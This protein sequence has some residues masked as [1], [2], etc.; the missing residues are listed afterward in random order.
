MPPGALPTA[1]HLQK[2]SLTAQAHRREAFVGWLDFPLYFAFTVIRLAALGYATYWFLSQ[3]HDWISTILAVL[4]VPLLLPVIF[5]QLSWFALAIA[6]RPEPRRAPVGFSVAAVTSFDPKSESF[7]MLARTLSALVAMDYKHETWVLDEG[8]EP[9]VRQLCREL[10]VN[11]FSRKGIAPFQAESG[12]FE[13]A[14]KH[15]N[16]NSWLVGHG[17]AHYDF[18]AN[19]DPDHVPAPVYLDAVLGHFDDPAIGYVQCAQAYYNQDA[20][21]VARGAAEETY[22]YYSSV[23]AAAYR[24]GHPVVTGC[25]TIHRVRALE[26]VDGFAAHPADDVLTTSNYREAGWRGVYIP[27]I[28][29]RGLVPVSWRSYI[30]QQRR[31]A[32]SLLDLKLHASHSLHPHSVM[33]AMQGIRYFL[34]GFFALSILLLIILALEGAGNA[35]SALGITL[36]L[37]CVFFLTNLYKQR[38]Y[39]DPPTECGIPWRAYLVRLVKWPYT[40]AAVIDVIGKRR[41]GYGTTPKIDVGQRERTVM[42]PQL[43]LALAIATVWIVSFWTGRVVNP[44]V[45][46]LGFIA[47]AILIAVSATDLIHFPAAHD[48]NRLAPQPRERILSRLDLLPGF[49]LAVLFL[50]WPLRTLNGTVALQ[51]SARHLMNGVFLYDLVR[52]GHIFEP[53]QFAFRYFA[54]FPALSMPY[55]PPL[56]PLFEAVLYAVFG[57]KFTVARLAVAI[58]VSVSAFLFYRLVLDQNGSRITA[59]VT[60]CSFLFLDLS[61]RLEQDVMLEFPALVFVLAAMLSL[62]RIERQEFSWLAGLSFG[63]WA[64]AGIWTKQ[65]VFLPIAPFLYFLCGGNRRAFLRPALWV[66]AAVCGIS[67]VLLALASARIGLFGM[68]GN[69]RPMSLTDTI[70]HNLNFY[71]HALPAGFALSGFAIAAA[72][73]STVWRR[74]ISGVSDGATC[75]YLAWIIAVSGVVLVTPAWEPRYLFFALPAIIALVCHTLDRLL[76]TLIGDRAPI[77][78][79]IGGLVFCSLNVVQP[80]LWLTGPEIAASRIGHAGANSVMYLGSSNGAFIF[81]TRLL[82][83]DLRATVLRADKLIPKGISVD[84]LE[85]AAKYYGPEVLAIESPSGEDMDW[86]LMLSN[87]KV[88]KFWFRQEIQSSLPFMRATLFVFRVSNPSPSSQKLLEERIGVLGRNETFPL[89]AP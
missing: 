73:I 69:W 22:G 11:H 57:V 30:D 81:A 2:P 33:Q 40:F 39:L 16:Y 21:V 8:D 24:F 88:L 85:E 4:S 56:F 66:S 1:Q 48:P 64:A 37:G 27:E 58:S 10:G 44:A 59:A 35:V 19:F 65:T 70:L 49:L 15:G 71:P 76:R 43:I 13:R 31:W 61:G 28:L 45:H 55:H 5:D 52:T 38:F 82:H 14:T 7:E 29:A 51:D 80:S 32:R 72:V 25:H 62:E 26:S 6:Q 60:C 78:M 86:Q 20:S 17:F 18:I 79:A 83:P 89:D 63:L 53:F 42:W 54:H 41:F 74:S 36:E 34:D 12:R 47:V 23:Q 68:P 46:C 77:A 84:R 75:F 9:A 67:A 87:S 50:F 3:I